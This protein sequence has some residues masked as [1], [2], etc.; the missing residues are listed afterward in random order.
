L[1]SNKTSSEKKVIAKAIRRN[2]RV[3]IFVVAK[4]KRRVSRNPN[5]R[6]WRSQKL[7]M[8]SRLKKIGVKIR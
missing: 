1:G 5:R 3:P 4:T 2:R 7:D 8:R 6:S